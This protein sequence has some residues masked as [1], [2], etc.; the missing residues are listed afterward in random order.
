MQYSL[1]EKGDEYGIELIS[2]KTKSPDKAA[3]CQDFLMMIIS[4]A[5]I[6][7]Y[8]LPIYSGALNNGPIFQ[9]V[10]SSVGFNVLEK[11]PS[12]KFSMWTILPLSPHTH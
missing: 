7:L 5:E 2:G 8:A 10:F 3:L 11:N 4:S 1:H 12:G 9:V 6:T